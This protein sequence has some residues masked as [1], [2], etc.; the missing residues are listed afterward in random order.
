MR[1]STLGGNNL[2]LLF[3]KGEGERIKLVRRILVAAFLVGLF[4]TVNAQAAYAPKME[5]YQHPKLYARILVLDQWGSRK[6]Y[7]CLDELWTQESHWNPKA[8]N[9]HSTAF[10]IPQFLN[11]TWGDYHFPI[12]PKSAL[13]QITAGL[14]YISLRYENPCEAWK[15][16][17]R[18]GWY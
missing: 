10:G 11:S 16:E 3:S 4:S 9:P 7:A 15:H 14:R 17:K 13:L 1:R 8:A 6:E 2:R 12:R 18:F 5:F